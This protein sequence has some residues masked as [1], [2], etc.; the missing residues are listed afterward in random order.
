M[1]RRCKDGVAQPHQRNGA[2]GIAQSLTADLRP[3]KIENTDTPFHPPTSREDKQIRDN[4]DVMNGNV[5]KKA[6]PH[7]K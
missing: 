6:T 1:V 7:R 3:W 2:C 5:A 4:G